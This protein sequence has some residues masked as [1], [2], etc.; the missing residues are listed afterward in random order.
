VL[1]K[2]GIVICCVFLVSSA[3]ST[4]GEEF[5]LLGKTRVHPS[6]LLARFSDPAALSATKAKL[7][8]LGLRIDEELKLVP[9]LVVLDFSGPQLKHSNRPSDVE[10]C[11]SRLLDC[12]RHLRA[13][14][15]FDYVEPD[16]VQAACREPNDVRYGDD[17]LWGL[18]NRGLDGGVNGADI[19]ATRAWEV[20]TGSTN[21]I[22]AVIDSGIRYTHRDLAPQMWRNP[23]EI[24]A[25]GIDDDR[26][27]FIDNIFGINALNGSGDP[28]DDVGHGTHAAGTIGAAANDGNPHVGVAWQVQL[29]ACKF[30]AADGFGV[31]SDAIRCIEFAV[32]KGAKII[33]ASWESGAFSRALFDAIVGARNQG[34]LFVT[35]AGNE[36]GD[37]DLSPVYPACYESDNIIAVASLDRRNQLA[38]FSNFGRRLVHL[39]AP[40]AEI[41][42]AHAHSDFA[43]WTLS[44]TSTAAPYVSGVAALILAKSSGALLPE[45]R[46]RILTTTIPVGSLR[47]KT[48]TG[49][50]LNAFHALTASPDGHLELTV[51]PQNGAELRAGSMQPIQVTVTDLAGVTNAVVTARVEGTSEEMVFR[52]ESGDAMTTLNDATYHAR[53]IPPDGIGLLTLRLRVAAPGKNPL[54][55]VLVYSVIA[56]PDNDDFARAIR[57]PAQGGIF[58][59]TNKLATLEAGE[60]LHARAPSPAGS[61]WWQWTPLNPTRVIVDSSGSSF[62]TVLAVYTNATIQTLQ[63]VASVDDSEERKQGYVIFEAIPGVAYQIA[64]AGYSARDT[65]TIHLRV[66]PFGAPD[67]QPPEV[68]IVSPLSGF[69]LTDPANRR[70]ILAGTAFDPEPNASGVEE[71]LVRINGHLAGRAF[72]TTNWSS[73][74][75]LEVGENS[76]QVVAADF[77]HNVS[78]AKSLT[79]YYR[80][81]LSP[82]DLLANSVELAGR[83]G[84][85]K[86]DN[87]A[88]TAEFGE[89]VHAHAGGG[90]SVWWSYRPSSDGLLT[91]STE[92]SSFDTV[93]GLYSGNRV[94]NLIWIAEND[95]AVSGAMFS[96]IR[97]PVKALET[98]QIAVD[99]R[100]GQSG[101]INL[102]YTFVPAKVHRLQIDAGPG[103]T[104]TQGSGWHLDGAQVLITAVASS[105]YEFDRW[106]GTMNA[107]EDTLFLVMT[108]DVELVALFRPYAFTDGF[109]SG[110]LDDLKWQSSGDAPWIVQE[111]SASF[112]RYAAR[113]GAIRDGQ[114][115]ALSFV[116]RCRAGNGA[117]RIRVSSEAGWDLL[118]FYLNGLQIQRW[119]GEISWVSFEFPVP[120]GVNR[121][122]WRYSKDA[123]GRSTGW[124]AAFL[125]NLELP[126]DVPK[127]ASTPARLRIAAFPVDQFLIHGLGQIKQQYQ[128][129]QSFDLR[130]WTTLSSVVA[131]NGNFRLDGIALS[132]GPV[133]FYR[134]ITP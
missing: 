127:D 14:G 89:P 76:V 21:V 7:G 30:M 102:T 101:T 85:V 6:R 78:R 126:L 100:G 119:S 57:L 17:T 103:G 91:L 118:E 62:D 52:G 53:L 65:G 122:E 44:G 1:H 111:Q 117:F 13:S 95:D 96:E 35:A 86:A 49:G 69:T 16:F 99:G 87:A 77:S 63:E 93:M 5:A 37:L 39:G 131:T 51:T 74:N 72:G 106:E 109:E 64:V 134:A 114:S 40:G 68:Q 82:N 3:D 19:D 113:S 97:Q 55:E 38:S 2:A 45:I 79:L 43:Y 60:P 73:T 90:K 92:G 50:R 23:E 123:G 41:Y 71:V 4:R 10:A 29:M 33:N 24:P 58:S 112:G 59:A 75:T 42:S 46:N 80:P 54:E 88:A 116:E 104:V 120:E 26:D 28:L 61:V 12:L 31:T 11:A 48:R 132:N 105:N 128:I 22:V 125:D 121:F 67:D 8:V 34:V 66:Q 70:V 108:N 110:R 107:F 133:R 36:R 25:N 83:N 98:Y 94:T 18:R 20:T 130:T 32:R 124:D 27:G 56:P 9:G 47:E 15:L 129:Q 84:V 81:F 115:S